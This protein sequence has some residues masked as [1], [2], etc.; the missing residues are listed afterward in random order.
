M[1][2]PLY[3]HEG[4]KSTDFLGWKTQDKSVVQSLFIFRWALRSGVTCPNLCINVRTR[5]DS[6]HV[7][8]MLI[9]H[10]HSGESVKENQFIDNQY[11]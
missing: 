11:L 2:L 7:L 5:L 4:N 1:N 10:G 8:Y 3:K 9:T 6:N